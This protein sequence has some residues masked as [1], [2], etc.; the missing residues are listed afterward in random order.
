MNSPWEP[1]TLVILLFRLKL[2]QVHIPHQCLL[3]D[4]LADI[5]YSGKHDLPAEIETIMQLYKP[6]NL[7]FLTPKRLLPTLD[8]NSLPDG[9]DLKDLLFLDA[10]SR[11]TIRCAG[12]YLPSDGSCLN[13]VVEEPRPIEELSEKGGVQFRSR[14]IV[15]YL[16][17]HNIEIKST[18]PTVGAGYLGEKENRVWCKLVGDGELETFRTLELLN[19]SAHHIVTLLLS[20][21]PPP[22]RPI[23]G[24]NARLWS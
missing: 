21:P 15:V 23:P 1:H 10:D 6:R 4:L 20:P 14:E 13:L 16:N 3:K 5:L 12:S 18:G 17:E 11:S 8:L 24:H 19:P 7:R 9:D 22:D 2:I